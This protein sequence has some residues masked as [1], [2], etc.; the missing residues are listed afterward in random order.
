[1]KYW[2]IFSFPFIL[3][4]CND[5]TA[6]VPSNDNTIELDLTSL[7][8]TNDNI[9][10]PNEGR[11]TKI[12]GVI[13]GPQ[14]LPLLINYIGQAGMENKGNITVNPDGTFDYSLEI[15]S[16]GFY[17]IAYSQE[18]SI[19]LYLEPGSATEIHADGSNMFDTYELKEASDDSKLIKE[20]FSEYNTFA[21]KQQ[22]V[23]SEMK[24]L[25]FSADQ[26]REELI[27][28]SEQNR[29]K[30]NEYKLAFIDSHA[31]APMLAFLLD[32]LNPAT[33]LEYIKKI[34]ESAQKS[35]QG[36]HY[37]D[38]VQKVVDSRVQTQVPQAAVPGQ[39][40]VGQMAPEIAFPNPDGET[41]KLSSL[42]GKLV[43]LDFWASWCKPCRME[44]P[45]VVRM[46]NKYKDKGFE[47][48]SFSLDKDL[49]RWKNAIK[50]DGLIWPNHASDL[51]GWNTATIP[52]YGFNGIPFTVL[53]DKDGKII[54]TNL[55]GPA[56]E[57]KLISLLG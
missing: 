24:S 50:Q 4:S 25:D 18:N 48:F 52:M 20:Y 15:N 1:M 43:L 39:I 14:N 53:I 41:I 19:L 9:L 44:N 17:S 3:V 46:Y 21:K 12:K 13:S 57:N 11:Q 31:E 2:I 49:S 7:D 5:E 40:A 45:N 42:K 10:I 26:K 51:K 35:L 55:R 32:H 6:D 54:E 38:L 37:N 29:S 27:G 8:D 33:E 28:K 22:Q 47:V 30:F 16:I 36:T 34:G 56:L 23:N